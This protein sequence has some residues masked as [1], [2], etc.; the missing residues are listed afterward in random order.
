MRHPLLSE[1]NHHLPFRLDHIHSLLSHLYHFFKC[2]CKMFI[3]LT[4]PLF[5]TF[6]VIFAGA[7]SGFFIA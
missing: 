7:S 6:D 5:R 2:L 4:C 3:I 1:I